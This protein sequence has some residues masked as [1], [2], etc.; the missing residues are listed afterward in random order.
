MTYCLVLADY[1]FYSYRSY[2]PY[3]EYITG[4]VW[5]HTQLAA[6][7]KLVDKQY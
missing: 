7:N 4:T 3:Y 6:E 5:T 1:D 2:I